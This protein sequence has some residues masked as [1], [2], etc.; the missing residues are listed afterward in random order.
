MGKYCLFFILL[1][2]SYFSY[3]ICIRKNAGYSCIEYS[4][5]D[6]VATG[7]SV[8]SGMGAAKSYSGS[9]C[10]LDWVEIVGATAQVKGNTIVNRFCGEVLGFTSAGTV[11][12]TGA[13]Q[14]VFGKMS[15]S[16]FFLLS[17]KNHVTQKKANVIFIQQS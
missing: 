9:D 12:T 14:V 3:E 7:F 8:S 6:S 5:C 13:A 15:C 2:I 11:A 4:V 1:P 16:L 17:T 10:T